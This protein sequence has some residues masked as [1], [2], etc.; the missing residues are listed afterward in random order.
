MKINIFVTLKIAYVHVVP[1]WPIYIEHFTNEATE[2]NISCQDE[3][4]LLIGPML[5]PYKYKVSQKKV[6][7]TTCNSSSKSHFFLGHLVYSNITSG[8]FSC[9]YSYSV[10]EELGGGGCIWL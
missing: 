1:Q 8:P 3:T 6:G 10:F 5:A 2:Q 7:F 4:K 9:I